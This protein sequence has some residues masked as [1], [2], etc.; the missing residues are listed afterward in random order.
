MTRSSTTNGPITD[1]G[2]TKRHHK[3]SSSHIILQDIGDSV[4]LYNKKAESP[5]N[6]TEC[7]KH[8]KLGQ[9]F[10]HPIHCNWMP[11]SVS[12]K[13]KQNTLCTKKNN[14]HHHKKYPKLCPLKYSFLVIMTKQKGWGWS[15]IDSQFTIWLSQFS[16]SDLF[17]NK[18]NTQTFT[19]HK[20]GGTHREPKVSFPYKKPSDINGVEGSPPC[21]TLSYCGIILV[22]CSE[23]S[24]TWN[25]VHF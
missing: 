24:Q 15:D 16:F 17:L 10:S 7:V 14:L 11:K 12:K 4:V 5:R 20:N 6:Q 18:K 22:A 3:P 2:I 13:M 23:S 21:F 1:E 8:L 25:P 19:H 9:T